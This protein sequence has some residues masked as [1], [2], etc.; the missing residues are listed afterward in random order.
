MGVPQL[1]TTVANSTETFSSIM[2]QLP[3]EGMT[4]DTNPSDEPTAMVL[5]EDI[6]VPSSNSVVYLSIYRYTIYY[7]LS[8]D[9]RAESH[10]PRLRLCG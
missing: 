4:L 3:I 2:G 5:H 10:I 8:R 7:S 6:I 9:Y 1:S